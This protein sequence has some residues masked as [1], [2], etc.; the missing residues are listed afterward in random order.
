MPM[1]VIAVSGGL[2]EAGRVLSL[3][4]A[5]TILASSSDQ[6]WTELSQRTA[7][8]TEAGEQGTLAAGK[9][10]FAHVICTVS[11]VGS[12]HEWRCTPSLAL[13]QE[14]VT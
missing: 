2:H 3:S 14:V 9:G 7:E 6:K 8:A 4:N 13:R 11:D 5:A 10:L 1:F 12:F